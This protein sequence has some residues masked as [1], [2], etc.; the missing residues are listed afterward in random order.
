M[1]RDEW[2]DFFGKLNLDWWEGKI[3]KTRFGIAYVGHNVI[4]F[5][6]IWK[7][8]NA[9]TKRVWDESESNLDDV[10][11][12]FKDSGI[13]GAAVAYPTMILYIKDRPGIISCSKKW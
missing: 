9:W 5:L 10:L 2:I 4:L 7:N 1:T 8:L 13:K 6:R 12:G 11:M 3:S